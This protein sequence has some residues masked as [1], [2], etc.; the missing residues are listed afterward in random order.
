MRLRWT[1]PAA[2]DLYSIARYIRRDNPAAARDVAKTIYDGWRASSIP[3]IADA[4]ENRQVRASWC[5][6]LC[7]TSRPIA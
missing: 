3:R 7:R 4:K 5:F 1:V 2:K 6:P